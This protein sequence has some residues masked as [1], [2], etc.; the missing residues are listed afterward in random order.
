VNLHVDL[1]SRPSYLSYFRLCVDLQAKD[2]S[3]D[4]LFKDAALRLQSNLAFLASIA[5]RS[6]KNNINGSATSEPPAAPLHSEAFPPTLHAPDSQLPKLYQ[7]L[8]S[9]GASNSI[10]SEQ[11]KRPRSTSQDSQRKRSRE[12]PPADLIQQQQ[13]MQLPKQPMQINNETNARY[14]TPPQPYADTNGSTNNGMMPNVSNP[15]QVQSLTQTF[16][17]NAVMNLNAL[18]AH[19]RGQPQAVVS[20]MEANVPGF[21]TLPIQVQLQQMTAVQNAAMQRQRQQS[22]GPSSQQSTP[23]QSQQV[24]S[25]RTSIANAALQ[26]R[27]GTPQ[28]AFGQ[29]MSS[30]PAPMTAASPASHLMPSPTSYP[31]PQQQQNQGGAASYASMQGAPNMPAHIQQHLLQQFQQQQLHNNQQMSNQ[32]PPAPSTNQY[33]G[34]TWPSIQQPPS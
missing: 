15:A 14:P 11:T 26:G 22:Q 31:S 21:R 23:P 33:N 4:H 24:Q 28:S 6:T 2:L 9:M 5:D 18:Q 19:Y 32:F 34:L 1:E 10:N 20:Y 29:P 3:S 16:G 30:S 8:S 25:R 27:P 17:P 12:Q 13:K 7:L